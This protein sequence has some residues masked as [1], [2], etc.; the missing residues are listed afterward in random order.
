[1]L[2]T[3]LPSGKYYIGDLVNINDIEGDGEEKYWYFQNK[4]GVFKAKLGTSYVNINTAQGDGFFKDNHGNT[5]WVDSGSIGCISIKEIELPEKGGFIFDF[6][7]PFNCNYDP[8]K[9]IIRFGSLYILTDELMIM[10][11]QFIS[12]MKIIL[13]SQITRNKTCSFIHETNYRFRK[14]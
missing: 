5:H 13:M 11:I 10:S 6:P 9:G 7:E 8:A 12:T 2:A 4:N 1:M 3:Y 14:F